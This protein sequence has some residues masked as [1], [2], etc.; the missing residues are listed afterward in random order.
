MTP[1]NWTIVEPA[2]RR[3]KHENNG[4]CLK[5]LEIKNKYGCDYVLWEWF[6]QFQADHPEA[7]I[8]EAGRDEDTQEAMVLKGASRAHWTKSAHNWKA[9]L[10]I[11]E[12][13]GD[14]KNIYERKWFETVLKPRLPDWITWYGEPGSSFPELPHIEIKEWRRMAKEGCLLLVGAQ[15]PEL[16]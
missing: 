10:D 7:H 13:Q 11:F 1:S 3:L 4:S 2:K 14:V 16:G 9:A 5:C 8:S 15:G 6:V 12:L